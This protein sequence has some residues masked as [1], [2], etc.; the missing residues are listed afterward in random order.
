MEP[1]RFES[2]M[3]TLTALHKAGDHQSVVETS[4]AL[5]RELLAAPDPVQLGWV[6]F[7]EVRALAALRRH[8]DVLAAIDRAEPVPIALG[9]RNASWMSSVAS[10]AAMVVG[11]VDDIVR[12]GEACLTLRSEPAEQI[13]CC[14]TVCHLLWAIGHDQRNRL[15]ASRLVEL[16]RQIGDPEAVV[17]G[18]HAVLDHY[19]IAPDPRLLALVS[20]SEA[21]DDDELSDRL[22][23]VD[24]VDG[25]SADADVPSRLSASDCHGNAWFDPDSPDDR[26]VLG[27]ETPVRASACARGFATFEVD[28][29]EGLRRGA[30][31]EALGRH[32]T[33][34]FQQWGPPGRDGG[35]PF[36]WLDRATATE[37]GAILRATPVRR[38]ALVFSTVEPGAL[39]ALADALLDGRSADEHGLETLTLAWYLSGDDITDETGHISD[40]A[41]ACVRTGARRLSILTGGWSHDCD[42][43][44][45]A[46]LV[47]A[48]ALERCDVWAKDADHTWPR[49]AQARIDAA[50]AVRRR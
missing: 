39:R 40:V 47:H 45:A 38:L 1:N 48:P 49:Q 31:P 29:L 17:R 19:A 9:A 46:E 28:S 2:Q 15:F 12:H 21:P 4:R 44:L 34:I 10:E 43:R 14:Q 36:F 41:Y 20:G 24:L 27:L 26:R 35:R 13:L 50:I 32:T 23:S 16:G 30:S 18:M 3:T 8:A 37:F 25:G 5:R 22:A 33:I 7:Y 6:R 42:H 11:R